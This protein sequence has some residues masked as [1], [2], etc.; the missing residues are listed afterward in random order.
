MQVSFPRSYGSLHRRGKVTGATSGNTVFRPRWVRMQSITLGSVMHFSTS[1]LIPQNPHFSTSRCGVATTV[2]ET[3][4]GRSSV[5]RV[6]V[7]A[8][9][10]AY[11]VVVGLV[12]QEGSEEVAL[13]ECDDVISAFATD[14]S[15]NSFD[16]EILPRRLPGADH[17]LDS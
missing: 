2:P 3:V 1:R 7:E 13:A 15:D 9:V 8:H 5:G 6:A 10:S 4:F 14:G 11:L 12:L 16:L 17:L